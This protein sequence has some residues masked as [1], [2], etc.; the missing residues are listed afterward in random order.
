MLRARPA[1]QLVQ[2]VALDELLRGEEV[3]EG[4]VGELV[5]AVGT[6]LED[7]AAVQQMGQDRLGRALAAEPFHARQGTFQLV[8]CR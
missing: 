5:D 6:L 1:E 8:Q 7:S 4:A 3:L 2:L